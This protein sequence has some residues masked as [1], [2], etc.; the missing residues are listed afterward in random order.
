[1]GI[2]RQKRKMETRSRDCFREEKVSDDISF[3]L[4]GHIRFSTSF[5]DEII[6]TRNNEQEFPWI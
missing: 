6:L 2:Q 4:D 1:M 5:T 3:L